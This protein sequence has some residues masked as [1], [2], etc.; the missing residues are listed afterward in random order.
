MPHTA[1]G[2][3]L[4]A[5]GRNLP[6][7]NGRFAFDRHHPYHTLCRAIPVLQP[8]ICGQYAAHRACS[9]IVQNAYDQAT[10]EDWLRELTATPEG[11]A[12]IFDLLRN[13]KAVRQRFMAIVD[14]LDTTSER[15]DA[16]LVA[17]GRVKSA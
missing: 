5:P 2:P 9:L 11:L 17:I 8:R 14:M 1:A 10:V 16:T 7:A 4:R 6:E 3:M 12:A 13:C 15:I